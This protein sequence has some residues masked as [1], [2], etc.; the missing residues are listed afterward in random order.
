[1]WIKQKFVQGWGPS[2]HQ[3]ELLYKAPLKFA[4]FHDHSPLLT[5]FWEKPDFLSYV[6]SHKLAWEQHQ[7]QE[8]P[9]GF[10]QNKA[11]TGLAVI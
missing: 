11:N 6:N 8:K 3:G 9:V 5:M 1:M 2:Q 4:E 7:Y 10:Y